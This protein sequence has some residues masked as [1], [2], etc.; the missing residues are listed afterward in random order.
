MGWWVSQNLTED[1]IES[2]SSEI[3]LTSWIQV[4]LGI[5]TLVL[6]VGGLIRESSRRRADK[7]AA[8]D[9]RR[10]DLADKIIAWTVSEGNEVGVDSDG[11]HGV[12]LVNDSGTAA[13]NV[14]LKTRREKV[15][16]G[17]DMVV[18]VPSGIPGTRFTLVPPGT[19]YTRYDPE[20]KQEPWTALLPVN[21]AS[22]YFSATI[23][24]DDATSTTVPLMP[25][26]MSPSPSRVVLLRFEVADRTWWRDQNMTLEGPVP[27]GQPVPPVELS[28]EAEFK[29]A[30]RKL[31]EAATG[32]RDASVQEAVRKVFSE[33]TGG[34]ASQVGASEASLADRYAQPARVRIPK[35]QQTLLVDLLDNYGHPIGVTYRLQGRGAGMPTVGSMWFYQPDGVGPADAIR[36]RSSAA[37]S[38]KRSPSELKTSAQI[39]DYADL[40]IASIVDHYGARNQSA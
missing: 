24:D 40:L 29:N 9:Q 11:E 5:F 1:P 25:R 2:T 14:C 8:G 37:N 12:V 13:L 34:E 31:R 18:A 36:V 3:A 7:Q 10:R 4:A 39:A 26:S 22:G 23:R 15:A 19:Y 38:L 17:S 32:T 27:S 28:W 30:G 16:V 33:L 20:T 35:A 6:A 21:T